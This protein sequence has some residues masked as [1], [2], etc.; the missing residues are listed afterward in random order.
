LEKSKIFTEAGAFRKLLNQN[1]GIRIV[2]DDE[3]NL[4]NDDSE[5]RKSEDLCHDQ[6]NQ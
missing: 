6:N 1:K 2:V 3:D 4:N 5:E